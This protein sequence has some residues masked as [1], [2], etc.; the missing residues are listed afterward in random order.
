VKI[1]EF[2]NASFQITLTA[3][4]TITGALQIKGLPFTSAASFTATAQVGY[5]DALATAMIDIKGLLS[6]SSTVMSLRGITAATT[7]VS[8]D[9]A[10]TDINNSTT[11]IGV[12][13]Y[14]AV[15]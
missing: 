15:A 6:P 4:G 2:V 5:W 14:R 3:K 12:V 9:L 7:S 10:T 1:G 13:S 8:T 11:L